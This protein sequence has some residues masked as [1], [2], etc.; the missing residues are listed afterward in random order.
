MIRNI[1]LNQRTV[2][3]NIFGLLKIRRWHKISWIVCSF[4][5]WDYPIVASW[6]N[7]FCSLKW[8]T[9]DKGNL[10]LDYTNSNNNRLSNFSSSWKHACREIIVSCNKAR[11]QEHKN[12]VTML[13]WTQISFESKSPA[14]YPIHVYDSAQKLMSS[15]ERKN[16][17]PEQGMFILG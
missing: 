14:T 7:Y 11:K 3:Y 2:N 9:K 4:Y 10:E 13:Y 16:V 5:K 6:Q 17:N 15:N 12:S 8:N 1:Y